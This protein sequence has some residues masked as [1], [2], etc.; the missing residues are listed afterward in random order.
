VP[1][2]ILNKE[3][4]IGADEE[5]NALI[6][7]RVEMSHRDGFFPDDRPDSFRLRL[8]G[9]SPPAGQRRPTRK[10]V[11][12]GK[13]VEAMVEFFFRELIFCYMVVNRLG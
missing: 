8:S 10:S 4:I 9:D 7:P 6:L 5:T 11:L 13:K 2:F 1:I 12:P 3:G